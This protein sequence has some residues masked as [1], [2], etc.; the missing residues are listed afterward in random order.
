[1]KNKKKSRRAFLK[2]S[3]LSGVALGASSSYLN[4]ASWSRVLGANER[5]N[6][7][8]VGCRNH[9]SWSHLEVTYLTYPDVEVV[10]LCDPD[11]ASLDRSGRVI[12]DMK[13]RPAKMYTDIRE[14]LENKDIDAISVATPNH[15][16]ALATVW[17]CQAGKD[18][19]VEKP[20]SHNIWE[21]RKMVEAAEKY[22]RV[23]QA[24]HDLRSNNKLVAAIEYIQSGA[25]GKIKYCHSWVY[26]RRESIGQVGQE[27][28]YIPK[29]VDYDLYCGPA[30]KGKLPR[31]NLHYDWHWQWDF[32]N[33]EI[34]NNGPHHL[35]VCRWVLGEEGLP[36]RVISFGGRYGYEDDGETPNTSVS[37]YEY[38]QAPILFEVRGLGRKRNDPIMD[39]FQT[40]TKKGVKLFSDWNS[41]SA[42]TATIIV[43]ENGFV[44][45]GNQIVYDNE[46]KEIKRFEGG[47]VQSALNFINAIRSR[48]TEDIKT[49]IEEGHLS[50]C[51]CHL[52]NISY[53]VGREASYEEV[54]EVFKKDY[55]VL[56]ALD[57]VNQH[58]SANGMNIKELPIIQGPWL[59]VDSKKEMF[60]GAYSEVANKYVSRDYREPFVIRDQV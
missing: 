47:K 44:D 30:P 24:D 58:L 5:V 42:H 41:K 51:L 40:T 10:A 17:G 4:A 26:K 18:V 52:G 27:G 13:A 49:P 6:L 7:C 12:H 43:C 54:N 8:T 31:V 14:M 29:S 56:D 20:V 19:C 37:L 48:N 16:H 21:G 50:A 22:D 15:W 32:G 39:S 28:G 1:M 3:A 59:E 25:L 57:R 46:G 33:G 45:M 11:L 36:S 23:V 35:D 9:G 60:K 38:K 53:R 2:Q 55:E 34:G